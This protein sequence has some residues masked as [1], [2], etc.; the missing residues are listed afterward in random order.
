ME[1]LYVLIPL[2][3]VVVFAALW[4]FFRAMD[5]GQFDDLEGPGM[6]I[7]QDDDR[8]HAETDE[9]QADIKK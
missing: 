4:V 9:S 6:R 3:V 7:L 8:A 5:G 1:A 2:S